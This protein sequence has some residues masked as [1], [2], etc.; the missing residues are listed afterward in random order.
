MTLPDRWA[1]PRRPRRRPI[2]AWT[3]WWRTRTVWDPARTPWVYNVVW[4]WVLA[5]LVHEVWAHP[6]LVFVQDTASGVWCWWAIWQALRWL[7]APIGAALWLI[8]SG[9]KPG[10]EIRSGPPT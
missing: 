6:A 2:A 7:W 5:F 4:V 8:R 3:A 9:W 10:D 1:R